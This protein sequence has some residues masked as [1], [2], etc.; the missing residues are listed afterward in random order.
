MSKYTSW[1]HK[2]EPLINSLTVGVVAVLVAT[3]LLAI[4]GSG[5]SESSKYIAITMLVIFFV[6]A[7]WHYKYKNWELHARRRLVFTLHVFG[8]TLI[9]KAIVSFVI[10]NSDFI[11]SVDLVKGDNEELS[12]RIL[13]SVFSSFPWYLDLS[14]LVVG[15]LML[16]STYL[17]IHRNIENSSSTFHVPPKDKKIYGGESDIRLAL[18][19]YDS[20][21]PP[22]VDVW[23]GRQSEL[24]LLKHTNN[25]VVTI[26]G[27]GGQ[28]KSALAAISLKDFKKTNP[29]CFWDWRDCREQGETFRTQLVS[30]I[31]HFTE[32]DYTA[33]SLSDADVIS[34]T[35]LLFKHAQQA[36]G[37]VVF[38]NVDHYVEVEQSLFLSD[39]SRFIN[40]CLRVEHNFTILLTCRPRVNYAS[41]RFREVYLRGLSAAEVLELFREKISHK[42]VDIEVYAE[43]FRK[44]T[45]GHPLWL[46]IIASQINRLPNSASV[47][48][49]Q[50]ESGGID[51]Q[52]KSM[53]RGVWGTL[54]ENQRLVL[55]CMSEIPRATESMRIYD[56]LRSQVKNHNK[57]DKAFQALKT[58][59]L[60]IEKTSEGVMS[61][62][63]EL[64]PMVKSFVRSEYQ[65]KT[66]RND[67]I[68]AII[69]QCGEVIIELRK[70]T[71]SVFT[72]EILEEL[73]TKAELELAKGSYL[74][75]IKTLNGSTEGL[76]RKGI[77]DEFVRLGIVIIENTDYSKSSWV[78]SNDFETFIFRLSKLF[79]ETGK[80]KI[81]LKNLD[82]YMSVVSQGTSRFI[83]LCDVYAYAYWLNEEYAE[84]ILWAEKG[85]SL[86]KT[87]GLDTSY[88]TEHNLALSRRDSGEV[89]KALEYFLRG[90]QISEV[91]VDDHIKSERGAQFY[92]NIGRCLALNDQYND[93]IKLYCK[94]FD[95]L[96]REDGDTDT[97]LNLGYASYW[98][99]EIL[100]ETDNIKDSLCFYLNAVYQ[101]EKRAAKLAEKPTMRISRF[102][103]SDE[104]LSLIEMTELEISNKC[105]EWVSSELNPK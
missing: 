97:K 1:F 32:G 48:L 101:W 76:V 54:N 17:V 82:Q 40:E 23:V 33:S 70:H 35:R 90:E 71:A 29:K 12:A 91:L 102:S 18:S 78:E 16:L 67:L 13:Y 83:G 93:A 57:F 55:R 65:H 59:S 2:N 104:Y 22:L 85:L 62:R 4:I 21:L 44:L 26:T 66:E 37:F 9:V 72:V 58:L 42:I 75:C 81:L 6:S 69:I 89:D 30:V 7:S 36:R 84:A 49:D 3:L 105:S 95:I 63:F 52:S 100:D 96:V 87:S 31:E 50:L 80:Y 15:F 92:G 14:F 99:A 10:Q 86:K 73:V 56:Y 38:D 34:L 88:D 39:L 47:F 60:I 46:N 103:E 5:L 25:G 27:I 43:K 64:H 68:D 79:A 28:G 11:A 8:A 24:E 41:S 51:D 77:Q 74:E 45:N 61:S 19:T 20:D 94:S 98:I 53:L